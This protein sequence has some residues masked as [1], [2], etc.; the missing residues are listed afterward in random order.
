MLSSLEILGVLLAIVPVLAWHYRSSDRLPYPPGPPRQLIIG[1]SAPVFR[2]TLASHCVT[3]GNLRQ[4]PTSYSWLTFTEWARKYGPLVYLRILTRPIII[5]SSAETA[6]D[7]LDIRSEIYSARPESYFYGVLLERQ[8]ELFSVSDT[9]P[10]FRPYRKLLAANLNPRAII[11]YRELQ[12]REA[13]KLLKHLCESPND[14]D[15]HI[16]RNAAAI[17]LR[18]AYGYPIKEKGRDEILGIV[19]DAALVGEVATQPGRF[20]VNIV[21]ALR[22]VPE[23]VPG[24]KWKKTARE[25]RIIMWKF[26]NIPYEWSKAQIVSILIF[27]LNRSA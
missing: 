17:I 13:V 20:L 2:L 25:W 22:H 11:A 10:R 16:R 21:P 5:L 15:D 9:H 6:S 19:E 23:W 7:L 8:S 3:S 14:W 27:H 26:T 12:E 24:T 1:K 18:L 4:L